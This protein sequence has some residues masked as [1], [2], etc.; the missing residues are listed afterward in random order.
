MGF[1]PISQEDPIL[2]MYSSFIILIKVL[3]EE[4]GVLK[5]I[6]SHVFCVWI[7]VWGDGPQVTQ[8][9]GHSEAERPRASGVVWL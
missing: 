3:R 4:I 2:F 7:W 8:Q 5:V 9:C 1:R 6:L